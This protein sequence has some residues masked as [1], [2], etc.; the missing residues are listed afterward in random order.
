MNTITKL[1]EPVAHFSVIV[2]IMLWFLFSIFPH[3]PNLI[4]GYAI[5]L[6]SAFF[7]KTAVKEPQHDPVQEILVIIFTHF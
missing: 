1:L 2:Q 6:I 5:G 3:P 7:P 4:L